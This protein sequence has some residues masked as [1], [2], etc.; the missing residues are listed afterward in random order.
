[1]MNFEGKN[2]LSMIVPTKEDEVQVSDE[3]KR[4][5]SAIPAELPILPLRQTVVY[6]LTFLPL[7]VERPETVKLIDDVVLGNRMVGLVTVKNPDADR[8]TPAD[9]YSVGTAAVVHRAMK[10]PTGSVGVIVQ[11]LERIRTT[12]FMQTEPYLKARIEVVPDVEEES[13]EV[14]ALS[15][16]TIELFQR[17]IGLVSYLPNE[18]MVAV[19]NAEEPRQLVY[20]V[21][22]AIRLDTEAAQEILEI[23]SIKE[24][25]RRLNSILTREL[26]VLE[27][28]QK[29]K[30]EAQSD[31]EKTQKEYFLRQQLKAIQRELGEEDEQTAEIGELRAKIEGAGMSEEAQKE[32]LR[33]L[34]RLSSMPQAAAEYSVI[35][36][37][38]DWLIDL[39]WQK[40]TDDNLDIT[41][42]REIL[43]E[44]HY[45]LEEI[46]E[47]ILEY[48]AVR[49]LRLERGVDEGT[50]ESKGAILNFVGPPGTGK[51]SLGRSIA[52]ALGREF[53]RMSLG[54]MRDEAEIRGH[55][56]T[57]VGALPGRIIQS[58]K[59]VASKNPVFM[60]DEVDKI[61]TDFRGDPSS[62]LLE[63][64][65]PEQN[66]T[67]RDH[68]LDVDWDLSPVMFITTANV[69][70]TIPAPLLDRMETIELDGYTEEE[71]LKIA[72]RYLIPRQREENSLQ[73]GEIQFEEDA[74]RVII[75][76]YTRES[77]LRNLERE[78]GSVCR[79]VAT[80]IAAGEETKATIT[81]DNVSD[82]LGKRKF[83]NEAAERT[84]VPGVATGLVVTSTGGDITF[85]E[86]TKMKG[87][88]GLTLT[89]QLGDVMKESAQAALSYVRSR[90]K[91]L[92]IDEAFYDDTD[93]HIHFPAGAIPKDGPSAG[94]AIA[95]ALVSLLTDTPV[96]CDVGMTGEITLRGTVLPIGGVKQKVLAAARTGL[97]T[98]ILPRHNEKDLDELP[99]EVREKMTFVLVD[100]MDEVLKAALGNGFDR[101][102]CEE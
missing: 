91:E 36:T 54:G 49:K 88:K 42:A 12:D 43:D 29:I 25:L 77:G 63:V 61:G 47:R 71:K 69:L 101:A 96:K 13:L 79:K 60:L 90:A 31:I 65:D 11:G 102:V 7:N 99:E 66:F 87:S 5:R 81:K 85:I 40:R 4:E 18:L 44:D 1:M 56:R 15:R 53:I 76:D 98:V 89:G 21:A 22:N 14:E 26:E 64:L 95:T 23:D 3:E 2:L 86:A 67:F 8:V 41:R 38:L 24:K 39:P 70:H 73:E 75:S 17:L 93:L 68:Y 35:R 50:K 20:L 57:Y 97:K 33:E 74:L 10:T 27:L 19:L 32:A 83:Y 16:N 92:N 58:I 34:D 59:R 55:R 80:K 100:T 28:G 46:K 84:E 72:Q 37:Y 48:L 6:P 78:I 30:D 52:R 82:F 62:A 45:D 9:L 51:T 94:V